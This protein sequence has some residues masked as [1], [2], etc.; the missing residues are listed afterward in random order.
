MEYQQGKKRYISLASVDR[1]LH[2]G[3][4]VIRDPAC[5]HI[6]KVFHHNVVDFSMTLEPRRNR[7]GTGVQSRRGEQLW[8]EQKIGAVAGKT[9]PEIII[10][11]ISTPFVEQTELLHHSSPEE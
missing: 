6:A 2:D 1:S 11:A 9:N 8:Y 10:Q 4:S 5:W 7:L 3:M